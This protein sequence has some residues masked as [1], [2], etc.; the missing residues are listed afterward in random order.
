MADQGIYIFF[1]Q[2]AFLT[3]HLRIVKR[4]QSAGWAAVI[5]YK[6]QG[7]SSRLVL[8]AILGERSAWREI[9]NLH[10]YEVCDSQSEKSNEA[11]I[12]LLGYLFLTNFIKCG[13][14]YLCKICKKDGPDR[15]SD[16]E[17]T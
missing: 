10:I 6:S 9:Q 11:P 4:L 7:S 14:M 2:T 17:E 13:G 15:N 16:T 12:F 3:S 5:V 8:P 1:L